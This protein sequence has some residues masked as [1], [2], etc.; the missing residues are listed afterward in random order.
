MDAARLQAGLT[1][2]FV[3]TS[4]F[5]LGLSLK[6]HEVVAPLRD[7]R[8][9][10]GALLV[11]FVILPL[12]ALLLS[13]IPSDPEL[14][15]GILVLGCAAGAAFSPTLVGWG[16][17]DL[18]WAAGLLVLL[19]VGSTILMSVLLPL[20]LE[21]VEVRPG[22]LAVELGEQLLAPLAI[23]LL[24]RARYPEEALEILPALRPIANVTLVLLLIVMTTANLSA[25]LALFGTGAVLAIVLL[26][27][28]AMTAG[29]VLGGPDHP[30]R[31]TLS[32]GSAARNYAA[33]FVVANESLAEQPGVGVLI[34]GASLLGL[35]MCFVL[36]G[37]LRRR[38]VG[39]GPPLRA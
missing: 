33:A 23:G 28:V 9:V 5:A 11:N 26:T 10:G 32:L 17:G 30:H 13:R 38:S 8:A 20:L 6:V 22:Q 4:M 3:L 35:G 21:D 1:L 2:A 37:E 29:W 25:M 19:I 7:A 24:T 12:A 15:N 16:R 14:A 36:A 18:A 39:R 27:G 31:V 34:T